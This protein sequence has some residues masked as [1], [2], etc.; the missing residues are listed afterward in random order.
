VQSLSQINEKEA[1]G[2]EA[3]PEP[4]ALQVGPIALP[5]GAHDEN[6]FERI[7]VVAVV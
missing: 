1:R 7:A 6:D 2:V 3:F 4:R 5:G